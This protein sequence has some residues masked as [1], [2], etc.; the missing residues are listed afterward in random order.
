M[1]AYNHY[2][3]NEKADENS[4][5]RLKDSF[6]TNIFL[7]K[8]ARNLNLNRYMRTRDPDPK[9]WSPPFTKQ[10]NP[11]EK[12]LC[13]GKQIADGVESLLGAY[14][15]STNLY[16]TLKFISKIQLVPLEEAGLL[17]RF[18]DKTLTFN[19]DLNLDNYGFDISDSVSDIFF[20]YF[21]VQSVS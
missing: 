2:E 8:I 3:A 15:M 11:T 10:A 13:T 14:F 17:H 18:P 1:L 9:I 12:L 21:K 7:F 20:K 5:C 6:V 16:K 4:V 19:L